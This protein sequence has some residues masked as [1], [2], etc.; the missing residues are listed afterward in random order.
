VQRLQVLWKETGPVSREQSQALW[1]EFRAL[2]DAVYRQ[3]EQAYT[4]HAAGLEAEKARAISLCEQVEQAND[5]PVTDRLAASARIREWHAA[6]DGL[7]E[8]PRAD[9]RPLRDRF[10]QAISRYESGLAEQDL[11]D[12]AAAGSN[13]LEAARHIRAY[14]RAVMQKASPGERETLRNSAEV[15]IAGVRRWPSGGLQALKQALARADS[16]SDPDDE[17]RESA[18]RMLCIRCEI[19]TSTPTPAEDEELR[20]D[21]QMRL[22]MAGLGQARRMDD[23]DWDAMLAEWI[24]IGAVAPETHEDL[25]RRFMRSMA[26]RPVKG[27][28]EAPFQGHDSGNARAARDPGERKGRRDGRG[29]PDTGGRR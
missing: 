15:F 5:N 18:L 12:A 22:L 28:R 2:C 7:G 10:E 19:H 20:R 23:R 1:D 29:R 8:L 13:L 9:A 25:E 27:L 4:L 17:A 14:E 6:F 21:C 16:A 3:R 24:G 11:R 26:Q